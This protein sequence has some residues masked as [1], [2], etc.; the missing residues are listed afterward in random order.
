METTRSWKALGPAF[1]LENRV[2]EN[3]ENRKPEN[4][5][6]FFIRA[7]SEGLGSGAIRARGKEP[8]RKLRT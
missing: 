3:N 5:L 1:L 4:F 8:T 7:L 6:S 2:R